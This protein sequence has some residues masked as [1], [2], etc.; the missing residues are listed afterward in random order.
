MSLIFVRWS[1]AIDSIIER[2]APSAEA[3]T[4]PRAWK[5]NRPPSPPD[6]LP[7]R[8]GSRLSYKTVSAAGRPAGLAR[9]GGARRGLVRSARALAAAALLA[10]SGALALPATAQADVLVSNLGQVERSAALD[11]LNE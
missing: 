5:H 2:R 4:A 1:N 6:R 8:R 10:L 3:V 9:L 11:A 7:P